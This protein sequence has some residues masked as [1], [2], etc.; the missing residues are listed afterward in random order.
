VV[1]M[2]KWEA[3]QPCTGLFPAATP[4]GAATATLEAISTPNAP[5][6]SPPVVLAFCT[7]FDLTVYSLGPAIQRVEFLVEARP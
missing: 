2:R 5:V 1:G 4:T 7:R 6:M 3:E